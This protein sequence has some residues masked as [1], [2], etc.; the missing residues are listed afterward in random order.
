MRRVRIQFDAGHGARVLEVLV[1]ATPLARM[2]GLLGRP[3]LPDDE[4]LFIKPCNMIH[5]V[6]MRHPI[7]V[8]FIARDGT[9]LEVAPHV[10]PRRLRGHFKA[11]SVLELAAGAAARHA[12][13]AGL[14]LPVGAI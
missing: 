10:G 9:V 13:I 4:A 14:A 3:M 12:I 11:H 6:G 5:T 2:R 7:D 1:A 8:V